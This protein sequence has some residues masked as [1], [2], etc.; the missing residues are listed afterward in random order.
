MSHQ[1]FTYC[2]AT[3]GKE[4]ELRSL[5]CTGFNRST[6]IDMLITSPENDS[7]PACCIDA[8]RPPMLPDT[9]TNHEGNEIALAPK[10]PYMPEEHAQFIVFLMASSPIT[11]DGWYW[12]EE[13]MI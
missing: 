1:N 10:W 6:Q 2:A 9:F 12:F 7:E 4:D 3:K 13:G 5:G 11:K 8:K